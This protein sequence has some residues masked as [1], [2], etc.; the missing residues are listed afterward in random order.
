MA[1]RCRTDPAA[2]G[3]GARTPKA[4]ANGRFPWSTPPTGLTGSRQ[5]VCAPSVGVVGVTNLFATAYA[6][7]LL[8]KHRFRDEQVE[9]RFADGTSTAGK[10]S[11][12]PR[13]KHGAS[14]RPRLHHFTRKWTVLAVT[15]P[16]HTLSRP[17]SLPSWAE[18]K[19]IVILC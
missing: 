15:V 8:N 4:L 6:G 13:W 12:E 3:P 17:N 7:P 10:I 19:L 2:S 1:A 9:D 11:P 18:T 16:C 5:S 14:E